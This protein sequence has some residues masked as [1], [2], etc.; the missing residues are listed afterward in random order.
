MSNQ[1]ISFN[2]FI[3]KLIHWKN[4]ILESWL[5]ILTFVVVGAL[6]GAAYSYFSKPKFIAET[7]FVLSE[8]G[9]DQVNPLAVLG[10]GDDGEIGLFEGENLLWLYTSN[11][12]LKQTLL[13]VVTDAN[14]NERMLI[15]WFNE[16]DSE[17]QDYL[18]E[19]ADKNIKVVFQDGAHKD[20]LDRNQNR[21]INQAISRINKDYLKVKNVAKTTGIINVSITSK[22]EMF[23]KRFC[24]ILVTEV[25][26]YYIATKTK[27]AIEQVEVL[28]AKVENLEKNTKS[29]MMKTAEAVENIPY[30]NPNLKSIHVEEQH[31]SVDASI[32]TGMYTMLAQ[33]LESAEMAL[34]EVTPL[35]QIVDSPTLPLKV[36][37]PSIKV[38]PVLGAIIFFALSI[39]IVIFRIFANSLKST[40]H[41]GQ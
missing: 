11:F 12:M 14:G 37:K 32:N 4:K 2:E 19:L 33:K 40:T 24:E 25:N 31:L 34:A 8:T 38:M 23:A 28:K 22:N 3:L 20:S 6:A 26:G 27:K 35:I 1:D 21:V 36:Q 9:S 18:E 10:L 29:S 41:A 30:P 7:N 15:N 16:I 17:M 39:V 13:T 5:L